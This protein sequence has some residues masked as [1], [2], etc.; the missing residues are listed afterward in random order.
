MKNVEFYWI[1]MALVK[2]YVKWELKSPGS[3]LDNC[4]WEN[5]AIVDV[6]DDICYMV[7]I[8]TLKGSLD[9]IMSQY[10]EYANT[11][12][13]RPWEGLRYKAGKQSQIQSTEKVE[14]E[15]DAFGWLL[16]AIKSKKYK[17]SQRFSYEV[18]L[19]DGVC[20]VFIAD[21]EYIS[22]VNDI[23]ETN[24]ILSQYDRYF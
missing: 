16:S 19:V 22:P 23:Q 4:E 12:N 8:W 5:W 9:E 17:P 6:V 20:K 18:K 21:D 1:N 11:L 7:E 14:E 10:E 2:S 3:F 24:E 15:S 13:C